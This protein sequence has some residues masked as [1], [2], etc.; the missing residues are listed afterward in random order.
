MRQKF[1]RYQ[2]RAVEKICTLN[3]VNPI[4]IHLKNFHSA[5]V[6]SELTDICGIWLQML[7]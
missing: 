6:T 3:T 5:F 4:K 2:Q 1:Q 7:F